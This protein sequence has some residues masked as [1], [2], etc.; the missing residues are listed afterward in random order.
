MENGTYKDH[1]DWSKLKVSKFPFTLYDPLFYGSTGCGANALGLITGINPIKF[2][3]RSQLYDDS[4]MLRNL[5][6]NGFS[7]YKITK[8]NLTN[9]RMIRNN[10]TAQHII[11]YSQLLC[12]GEASWIVSHGGY[13]F[14]NFTIEKIDYYNLMN[15][16]IISGYV[17]Y[18]KEWE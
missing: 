7:C 13:L 10:L 3:T 2:K 18:K 5:R 12:K 9:N 6:K 4:F 15:W 11:L 14:H 8:S 1:R 16:P 17:I